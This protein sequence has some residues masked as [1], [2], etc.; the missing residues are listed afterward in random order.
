[1]LRR[2]S[3]VLHLL[4]QK[5]EL[6]VREEVGA[7]NIDVFFPSSSTYTYVCMNVCNSSMYVCMFV[8]MYVYFRVHVR[9]MAVVHGVFLHFANI[10][11]I[12]HVQEILRLL[13]T[14]GVSS[15]DTTLS[16]GSITPR[17]QAGTATRDEAKEDTFARTN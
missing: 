1:M 9:I 15:S 10:Q 16:Y 2:H 5:S 8:C 14:S 13:S 7:S 6:E 4:R 12:A 3:E 17:S 11:L